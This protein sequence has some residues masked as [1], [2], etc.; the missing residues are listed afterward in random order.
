MAAEKTARQR[1]FELDTVQGQAFRPLE[2]VCTAIVEVV[3]S[4]R[5]IS[6]MIKTAE[7]GYVVCQREGCE[8]SLFLGRVTVRLGG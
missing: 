1:A 4:L 2:L 5:A 8:E 7:Y 6:S 3:R